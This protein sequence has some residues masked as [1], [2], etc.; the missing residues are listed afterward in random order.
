MEVRLN[1]TSSE[2]VESDISSSSVEHTT[3]LS[4]L[5]LKT[6]QLMKTIFHTIYAASFRF[7]STC[8]VRTIFQANHHLPTIL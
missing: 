5:G 4:F 1:S 3:H 6:A 8:F 2:V 7:T